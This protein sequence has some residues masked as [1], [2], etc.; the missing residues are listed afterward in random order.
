MLLPR[1]F[2]PAVALLASTAQNVLAQ[3]TT[4]CFPMNKTCPPNPA[5][6]M[7]VSFNFNQTPKAGTWDTVVNPMQYDAQQGAIFT[8]KKQGDC[9]TI[10]SKF[11]FFW[12]RTE[13]IMK[14]APGTGIISSVM[15][16]SDNLDEIDWEFKGGND[17][18]VFSNYFGKGEPDFKNGGDHVV[19]NGVTGGYHN[20]TTIWTKDALDFYIDGAKVRTVLYKDNPKFFPQTPMRLSLGIWAGGDPTL[21]KGTREWAG[22]DTDYSKGPF[23]FYVKSTQVTDFSTGKEYVYGDRTGSWESIQIVSG[24]STVKEVITAPPKQPE[25]TVAEKFEAL[26]QSSKTA[27]YAGSAAGGGLL[28]AALLFYCIRQRRRGSKE[29][30]LAEAKAEEERRELEGFRKAGIN[31]DAFTDQ[32]TEY[33]AKEM[34]RDGLSDQNSYSVPTSPADANNE[35]WQRAAA[36]GGGA[37]AGAAAAGAMRSPMP[38]LRDG[39]Q[40]P[41]VGTPVTPGNPFNDPPYSDRPSTSHSAASIP[42]INH[43]APMPSPM[44]AGVG[45][46]RQYQPGPRSFSSPHAQMR[47]SPGPQQPQFGGPQ[48]SNSPSPMQQMPPRSHTASP[49]YGPNYGHQGYGNQSHQGPRGNQNGQGYWGN[50]GYR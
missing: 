34:R 46:S 20:Y 45:P 41:R 9:P 44:G 37:A 11:Y 8:I 21:P 28:L 43:A 31:P 10:R 42:S 1:S 16:L 24:N 36:I 29:A 22:G 7:D 35:K 49:G 38:L 33:N 6:G 15:F 23:H 3:V 30:K 13:V 14:A 25:P 17:T 12:G 32:A 18:H 47:T 50:D 2:L 40:S 39:A 27:I 19:A 5:L 48:R 4:D 26:P